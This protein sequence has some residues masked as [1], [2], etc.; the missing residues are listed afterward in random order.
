MVFSSGGGTG[1]INLTTPV[2]RRVILLELKA[3]K[4]RSGKRA[5]KVDRDFVFILIQGF[6]ATYSKAIPRPDT[7]G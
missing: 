1:G 7:E 5:G 6:K 4:E 3:V 2:V